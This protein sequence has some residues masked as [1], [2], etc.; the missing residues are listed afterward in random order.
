MTEH[1]AADTQETEYAPALL[2][3]GMTLG[4]DQ[5]PLWNVVDAP[6]MATAM[7]NCEAVH[8]TETSGPGSE[9]WLRVHLVPLNAKI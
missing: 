5:L 7:Q 6:V 1:S 4:G 2:K 8:E 3:A 9:P